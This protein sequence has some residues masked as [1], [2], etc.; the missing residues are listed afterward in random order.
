MKINQINAVF[1]Y[2]QDIERS[3]EFYQ[4]MLDLGAP[5]VETP[6]WV[7]W[8]L[9]KGSDFAICK[10]SDERLESMVPARSSVKFSMV[11]DDMMKCYSELFARG[12]RLLSQPQ[13]G[14]GFLFLEFQDPDGNVLR[15]IQWIKSAE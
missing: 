2:V 4:R 5:A 12:A 3:K 10:A 13:Q 11:V 6:F 1:V 14:A 9:P 8:K 15:L 7:E